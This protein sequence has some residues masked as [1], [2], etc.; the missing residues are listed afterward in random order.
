MPLNADPFDLIEADFIVA[1]VVE[2]RGLGVRVRGHLLGMLE[3]GLGVLQI[4]RDAGAPEGVIANGGFW[5]KPPKICSRRRGEV[6]QVQRLPESGA[7][8]KNQ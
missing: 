3:L 7:A 8:L 5:P 1:P 4:G 6:Y 2:P